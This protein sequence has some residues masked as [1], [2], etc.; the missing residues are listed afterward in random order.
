[1][2][3]Q[4]K[5]E[6]VRHIGVRLIPGVNKLS[7]TD[8][9]SFKQALEHPMNQYLVDH[10]EIVLT[11]GSNGEVADSL[12]KLNGKKAIELIHDT[13]ELAVLDSFKQEEAGN[14]NRKTVLDAINQQ[15]ESI[16]NP[17]EDKIVKDQE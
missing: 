2:L 9:E 8:E 13:F 16:K 11:T 17:P 15:I 3:V 7:L 12:A 14:G 4:N 5:G 10:G 6:Y 1:M